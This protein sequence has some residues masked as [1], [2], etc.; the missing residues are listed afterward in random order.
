MGPEVVGRLT[1]RDF[2]DGR[3]RA[4]YLAMEAIVG[5]G[6]SPGYIQVVWELERR[7]WLEKVGEG[8]LIESVAF[9]PTSLHVPEYVDLIEAERPDAFGAGHPAAVGL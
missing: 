7:Q 6:L 9:C 2:P 8:W 3:E 5:R 1:S 4:V